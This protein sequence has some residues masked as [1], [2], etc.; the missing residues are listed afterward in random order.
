VKKRRILYLALALVALV[1]IALLL[2]ITRDTG[3]ALQAREIDTTPRSFDASKLLVIADADMSGTAYA[4]GE[5]KLIPGIQDSLNELDPN[6]LSAVHAS[7]PVPN[8]VT[9]WPGTVDISPDGSVAY[10]V[11]SKG[12]APRGVS[13]VANVHIDLLEGHR[14][15]TIGLSADG[16]RPIRQD[17]VGTDPVSVHAAPS[18][19][20]LA[21]ATRD[22]ASPLTFVTLDHGIPVEI[23]RPPLTLPAVPRPSNAT[24]FTY[25]RIN[26]DGRRIAV[27]LASTHVILGE[28][29]L[30]DADRPSGVRFGTPLAAGRYISIGRWSAD[31]RHYIVADTDW[32]PE[33]GDS[34]RAGPGRL[35]AIACDALEGR[36][37][38]SATVSYGPEGFEANRAGDL[39]IVVNMER[40]F[41]PEHFPFTLIPR[42]KQAS[43]SLVAFD[44]A[45][46]ALRTLDGPVAFD[47]VLPEDAVFDRDGDLIAVAVFHD[48][49]EA[50]ADGWIEL[51]AVDR[52]TIPRLARTG[53]RIRVPRG[54]HDLAVVY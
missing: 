46:G 18:G 42:R 19:S 25:A 38:S 50:P 41:A 22:A 4:D 32:G 14:L 17:H 3:P 6:E 21:I 28:I 27:H 53:Q 15:T 29:E 30:D 36:I 43:L 2:A 26:P 37:V 34:L 39:F 11:E 20:W 7:I 44:A 49:V 10:V 47:A 13:R 12:G 48:R 40:T 35:I 5:L 52:T 16:P 54:A 51:F 31:G 8:S 45:T 33:P 1:T 9:A 23:R 24:G